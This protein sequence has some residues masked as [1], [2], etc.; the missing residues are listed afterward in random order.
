MSLCGSNA[1]AQS[2]SDATQK[3]RPPTFEDVI[4]G[5]DSTGLNDLLSRTDGKVHPLCKAIKDTASHVKTERES[6]A[7]EASYNSKSREITRLARACGRAW[8]S[9][10]VFQRALDA[11][12]VI[13]PRYDARVRSGKFAREA[14]ALAEA[15]VDSMLSILDRMCAEKKSFT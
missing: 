12:R 3:K 5:M 4:R 1:S 10:D 11:E 9:I 14:L 2:A 15:D 8:E 13:E 7:R 6:A